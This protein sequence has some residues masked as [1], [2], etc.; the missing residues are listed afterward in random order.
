MS[1]RGAR[2]ATPPR[3]LD[4]LAEGVAPVAA[5]FMTRQTPFPCGLFDPRL[6]QFEPSS[7]LLCGEQFLWLRGPAGDCRTR[8]KFH[9]G[10]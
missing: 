4:Y 5:E 10:S 1:K 7:E 6:R 9:T 3:D 2:S 8:A